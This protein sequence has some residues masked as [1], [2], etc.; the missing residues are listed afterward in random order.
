M[1]Y[2]NSLP[3]KSVG[4]FSHSVPT[5]WEFMDEVTALFI[6]GSDIDTLCVA[7]KH[8]KR[9]DFLEIMYEK[10]KIMSEV[11]EITVCYF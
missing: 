10:L 5:A 1:V 6:L 7:P 2:L 3:K 4:K 11:T 8:V 9:D